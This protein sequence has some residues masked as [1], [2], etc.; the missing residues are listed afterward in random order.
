MSNVDQSL[1]DFLGDSKESYFMMEGLQALYRER[2]QAFNVAC[3]LASKNGV[4]PPEK[5]DYELIELAELIRMNGQILM[6]T[7]F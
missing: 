1:V 7:P 6:P 4:K 3:S 2:L 5:E